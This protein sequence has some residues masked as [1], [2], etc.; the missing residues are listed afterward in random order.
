M[1]G[2]RAGDM[3]YFLF[4]IEDDNLSLPVAIGSGG[5]DLNGVHEDKETM[6]SHES[7]TFCA[8]GMFV[9]PEYA[10]PITAHDTSC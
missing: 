1:Q 5:I 8:L 4:Y 6:C 9:Y 7:S 3:L 10:L 2:I